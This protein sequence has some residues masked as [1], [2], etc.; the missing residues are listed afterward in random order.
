METYKRILVP[1]DGSP[2]SEIAFVRAFNLS[3]MIEGEITIIHVFHTTIQH[4]VL[5][6][7]PD[8]TSVISVLEKEEKSILNSMI[9]GYVEKGG[10]AGLKVNTILTKGHVA[11]KIIKE[12]KNHDLVIIGSRGHSRVRDFLL[13]STAEKVTRYARCTVMIVREG[14]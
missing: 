10:K 3:R 13:G 9:K 12:S 7:S 5:F 14:V 4:P 6:D 11:D 8:V 1:V 2:L